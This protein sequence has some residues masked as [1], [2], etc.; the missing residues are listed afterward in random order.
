MFTEQQTGVQDI[1]EALPDDSVMEVT[2]IIEPDI[3]KEQKVETQKTVEPA[4]APG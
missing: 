1:I 3:A 2:E 4:T